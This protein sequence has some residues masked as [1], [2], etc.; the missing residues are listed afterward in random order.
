LNELEKYGDSIFK[1]DKLT[2]TE[3][4]VLTEHRYVKVV[5]YDVKEKKLITVLLRPMP[6]HSST[7]IFLVWS[8]K[9]LLKD[10]KGIKRI[11]TDFTVD[12]DLTFNYETKVIAIEVE[13]GSLLKVRKRLE[14]KAEHLND[15]Y[16]NSWF[17]VV[18]NKNLVPKYR[19]YG[20]VTTRRGVAEMLQK[21]LKSSTPWKGV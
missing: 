3:I 5:E 10:I 21:M 16:G 12:A 1:I 17:F 6:P 8:I 2:P 13:T 20:K 11:Q 14:R 7:H 9:R 15:M 4:D 18:S 19:K